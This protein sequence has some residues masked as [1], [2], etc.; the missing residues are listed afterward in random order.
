M[1]NGVVLI[2]LIMETSKPKD[3]D[4]TEKPEKWEEFVILCPGGV[5]SEDPRGTGQFSGRGKKF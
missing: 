1:G 2:V 4:T 5:L 3:G